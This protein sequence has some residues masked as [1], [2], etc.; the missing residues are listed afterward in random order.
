VGLGL[1]GRERQ[2]DLVV[3]GH[4]HVPGYDDTGA[5]ALLNPGSHAR[6]RGGPPAHAELVPAGDGL[7]GRLVERD[8]SVRREFR[9]ERV[10]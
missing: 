5:V 2:A 1:L 9:V 7:D 3:F 4:S 8:G 6:P 10:R